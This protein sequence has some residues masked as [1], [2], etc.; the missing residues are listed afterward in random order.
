MA[1]DHD[2]GHEDDEGRTTAP[3]SAYTARQVAVGFVVALVGLALVFGVPL[4][5]TL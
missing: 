5:L 2:H 4:A 1:D 3:Q